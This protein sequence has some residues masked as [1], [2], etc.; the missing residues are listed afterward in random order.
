MKKID[1]GLAVIFAACE[2]PRNHDV[3]FPFR[4][5]SNFHYL[6]GLNEPEAILVLCSRQEEDRIS[7]LC[8]SQKSSF[9]NV[10]RPSPW[11][12]KMPRT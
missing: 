1:G 10:G 5:D 11:P 8:S 4:Q 9:G 3:C 6:T 12:G 2:I 7:T